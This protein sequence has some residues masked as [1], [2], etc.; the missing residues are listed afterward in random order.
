MIKVDAIN[1]NCAG[2]EMTGSREIVCLEL[3]L[4][5][6]LLLK[7]NVMREV[8]KKAIKNVL[9]LDPALYE[10]LLEELTDTFNEL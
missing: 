8:D 2:V 3:M 4:V 1:S 6:T 7:N 9:D 5:V 10:H